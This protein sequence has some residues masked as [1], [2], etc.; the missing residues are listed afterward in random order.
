MV[1]WRTRLTTVAVVVGLCAA[2]TSC[3]GTDDADERGDGPVET[4]SGGDR[5]PDTDVETAT[6]TDGPV[7]SF[8]D[9]QGAVVQIAADGS[10]R[11]PAQGYVSAAGSGSGF[12]IDADGTIVTNAHVVAGAATLEVFLGENST[13]GISAS[14]LGISECNDLAVIKV[15]SDEPLPYL[16]WSSEEIRPGIPVYAAGFP[17]G[18]REYTLTG[19]II[20]KAEGPGDVTGTS[21][22]D[23]TLEHDAAIQPGNSGG[24]LL[25]EDGS[26]LGV[27]YAGRAVT[28]TEQFYAIAADLAEPLVEQ[29]KEGDVDSIGVNGWAV[30]LDEEG[31]DTGI[32]VSAVS[33]GSP[34]ARAGLA[35]GDVITYLNG[36]QM[37]QEGTFTDY[38]NVIRTA[39]GRP[40][41]IEAVRYDTGELLVGELN[42]DQ[43]LRVLPPLDVGGEGGGTTAEDVLEL[44]DDT[45]SIM[46][47]VPAGWDDT[48]TGEV[49]G[50]P[51][52]QAAP[53]LD[54]FIEGF[55]VPGMQYQAHPEGTPVDVALAEVDFS[56]SCG[57]STT[58]DFDDG[59]YVG[60][61]RLWVGCGAE[62]ATLLELAAI[63]SDSSGFTAHLIVQW[64]TVD[65]EDAAWIPLTTFDQP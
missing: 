33:P 42:S 18:E 26:V 50:R 43:A 15:G 47:S 61:V 63:P 37:G 62:G 24:P 2:T 17:L 9:A 28:T 36:L 11:D 64:L 35:P 13:R 32:W 3:G 54:A 1:Q 4:A 31:I 34:A 16:R 21:S 44:R 65:E 12:L 8:Q 20:A 40:M 49:T 30:E 60:V 48:Y 25:A 58:E 45:G 27:N 38:C 53:D 19:G 46:V 10:F 39:S 56:Q 52:I 57:E 14:V 6:E 59:Y 29:L 5:A 22:I 55:S 23:H 7:A 51:T 41:N